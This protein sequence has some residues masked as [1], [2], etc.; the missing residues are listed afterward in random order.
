M[1]KKKKKTAVWLTVDDAEV[2]H[3]WAEPDGKREAKI[4]PTF[5]AESG[6]PICDDRDDTKH[7]GEDMIYVRTEVSPRIAEALQFKATVEPILQRIF[8]VLY[9]D[10][11]KNCFDPNKEWDSACDF[12]EMVADQMTLLYGKPKARARKYP[13]LKLRG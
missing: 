1:I 11:D 6:V 5:Y 3:I 10:S 8:D 7:E 4:A 13:E 9:F 2:R 12:I